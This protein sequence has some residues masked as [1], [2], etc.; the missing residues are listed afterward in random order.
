MPDEGPKNIRNLVL[1][2]CDLRQQGDVPPQRVAAQCVTVGTRLYLYGGADEKQSYGDLHMLQIETTQWKCLVT[3][4]FSKPTSRYG[5]TLT[6]YGSEAAVLYGGLGC[7]GSN[8]EIIIGGVMQNSYPPPPL[9]GVKVRNWEHRGVTTSDSYLLYVEKLQWLKLDGGCLTPP[10]RAFHSASLLNNKLFVYGGVASADF[11][12]S[13]SD[14]WQLDLK[15]HSWSQLNPS[16]AS[17]GE[18]WGH[19]SVALPDRNSIAVFGGGDSNVYTLD[20]ENISWSILQLSN[21]PPLCRTFHTFNAV[22][23]QRLFVFAGMTCE[24]LSDLYVI[25]LDRCMWTKPLYDGQINIR[26]HAASPV[27]DKLIVFG[28]A[29]GKLSK[30]SQIAPD[31][32]ALAEGT[33][34]RISKKLFFLSCLEIK[35]TAGDGDYKFKLVTVGDSGVGKSCLLTRFVEDVYKDVH[36]AT[37]GV[38]FSTVV[39]MVKGKLVKMQLW[40]TAGQERFGVV[41]GN[42]YRHA[43]GFVFVYDVTN[44]N[45]FDNVTDIWINQVK[46]HH[47]L[48]SSVVKILVGNKADLKESVDVTEEEGKALADKMGALF[49]S[50]SARTAYNVDAA[51]LNA[52]TRLVDIRRKA[53]QSKPLNL[54]GQGGSPGAIRLSGQTDTPETSGG[55]GCAQSKRTDTTTTT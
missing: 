48:G 54:G 42:Y 3:G 10:P 47:D 25:D 19:C 29:K 22:G 24:E 5:H 37:I 7:E 20:V 44:R 26:S 30:Y 31:I 43:D 41:T 36:L 51:F 40:D 53:A 27:H 55:C 34:Q 12:Q 52:A 6:T 11:S 4:G 17:P 38:D 46:Q 1:S 9:M 2:V 45:S 21:T 33:S 13:H 14:I 15:D 50:T 16:G 28:G 32:D 39:T 23:S 35:H 8:D 18:R 49:V